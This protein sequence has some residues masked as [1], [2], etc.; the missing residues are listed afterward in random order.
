MNVKEFVKEK[1]LQ[2]PVYK[3]ETGFFNYSQYQV[4]DMATNKLSE[5]I[6]IPKPDYTIWFMYI[7]SNKI[8]NILEPR[9]FLFLIVN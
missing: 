7:C 5:P 4:F 1:I 8:F 2:L 3:K 6:N 9:P